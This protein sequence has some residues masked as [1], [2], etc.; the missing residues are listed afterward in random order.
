MCQ[1]V[2]CSV[3]LSDCQ[4][5][6]S[7]YNLCWPVSGG[8][9]GE[10]MEGRRAA[11]QS[12][13]ST[14]NPTLK[15]VVGKQCQ[16]LSSPNSSSLPSVQPSLTSYDRPLCLGST[17]GVTCSDIA[18]DNKL[19]TFIGARRGI[20]WS[21]SSILA[22]PQ[23]IFLW[24]ICFITKTL[25]QSSQNW[26]TNKPWWQDSTWKRICTILGMCMLIEIHFSTRDIR[27]KTNSHVDLCWATR[28]WMWVY[29]CCISILIG[30]VFWCS[31]CYTSQIITRSICTVFLQ[32]LF[33]KFKCF[34][35]S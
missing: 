26:T 6:L 14:S 22:W 29:T 18:S 30:N 25:R 28:L 34:V 27:I 3:F 13:S 7:E 33:V 5:L 12:R 16:M 15:Y 1:S 24:G 11:S 9:E 4:A 10:K 19:L 17:A 31:L 21:G 32:S 23:M 35:W 8:R 20:Q 2:T